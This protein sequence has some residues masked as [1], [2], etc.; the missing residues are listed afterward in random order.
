MLS[1]R[2]ICPSTP[3]TPAQCPRCAGGLVVAMV[4]GITVRV[5]PIPVTAAGELAA[6]I[7][8][9]LSYEL[10]RGLLL[11]RDEYRIRGGRIEGPILIAHKCGM[12]IAP[13]YRRQLPMPKRIDGGDPN[14][15]PF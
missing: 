13:E 3:A 10:R 14:A 1:R 12:V 4:E 5:D 8:G 15:I 7:A 11:E 2:E 9:R 6:R